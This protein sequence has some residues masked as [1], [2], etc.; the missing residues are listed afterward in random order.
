MD[1]G[2]IQILVSGLH[3][4]IGIALDVRGG[5]MFFTDLGGNLYAARLDGSEMKLLQ[6]GLGSLTGIA[7]AELPAI[8]HRDK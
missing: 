1:G 7:Y 4:G 3:E 5:R 8:P 2:P 6:S